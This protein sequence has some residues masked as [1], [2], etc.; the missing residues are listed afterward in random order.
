MQGS[1]Q[2]DRERSNLLKDAEAELISRLC[3]RMPGWV[4]PDLLTVVGVL[5]GGLVL[6]GL[7]LGTHWRGWLFI[8]I[9]GLAVHWFGDSLDGRLAYYRGIPRK[10]YGFS[11]DILADWCSMFLIAIGFYVYLESFPLLPFI[12]LA[13]YGAAMLISLLR[14][15]IRDE[16][17]I[18]TF[19]LGPTEMRILLAVLILV[20]IFRADTLLQIGTLGAI[21]LFVID[22]I[23]FRKLLQIADER[24]IQE[25]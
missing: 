13:A 20:E 25:G 15:K 1:I 5:G 3:A 19:M 18:D 23:D 9:V 24:D 6:A 2:S 11:L 14:F 12:F 7:W 10:W 8:S 16:Y 4:T 22:I 17:S 21:L